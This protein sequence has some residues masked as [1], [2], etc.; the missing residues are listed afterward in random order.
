[1]LLTVIL[2]LLI[3]NWLINETIIFVPINLLTTLI[4]WGWWSIAVAILL[5]LAWC[6]AED[7]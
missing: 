6:M 7:Q 3:G 4:H 1:M 2:L 5:F